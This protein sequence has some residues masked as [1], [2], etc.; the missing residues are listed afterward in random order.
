MFVSLP[1]PN[2]SISKDVPEHQNDPLAVGLFRALLLVAVAL[3]VEE[4]KGPYMACR[5]GGSESCPCSLEKL[6]HSQ[7]STVHSYPRNV[8][9]RYVSLLVSVFW[10]FFGFFCFFFFCLFRAAPSAYGSSQARGQIRAIT[11]S[12]HHSHS[13]ARSDSCL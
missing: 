12:L 10:F 7:N 4:A 1:P 13:N 11:A 2:Q 9:H 3:P 5:E 6:P 8:R